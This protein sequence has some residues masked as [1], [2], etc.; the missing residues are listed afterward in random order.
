MLVIFLGTHL[1]EQIKVSQ[2]IVTAGGRV[3]TLDVLAI[4][5]R[6]HRDVLTN[7]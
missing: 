7:R 5:F 2:V 3:A 6:L 4:D 1:D